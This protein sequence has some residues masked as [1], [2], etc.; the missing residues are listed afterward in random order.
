VTAAAGGAR[1]HDVIVVGAG[2]AGCVLAA[3]LSEDPSRQVLLLEAGPDYPTRER[4]PLDIADGARLPSDL[5][6]GHDWHFSS[7]PSRPGGRAVPLPRGRIVGGSSAVNGTFA[8]RGPAEDYDAWAAAGNDGWGSGDV[9]EVFCR[10]END[11]DFGDRPWHGDSG[12]VP[13]RRYAAEEQSVS[14]AAFLDAAEKAGHRPVADHNQPGALG[15]GPLPVNTLHRLRMSAALTHLEPARARPNLTVRGGATV[16]RVEFEAGRV[17]GV[18]LVGG[19][20]LSADLVVLAAG[21]YASPAILLRSGIGP[22]DELRAHGL[23]VVSDLPGVGRNLVDHPLAS[24]DVAV[25]PEPVQRP[26][27]QTMVTWSSDGTD[28]PPDLHLF[29]C[30]PFE[31]DRVGG[32]E[33]LLVLCVGLLDPAGRGQVQLSSSD[34]TVPPRID[35]GHLG[36]PADADRLIAGIAAARRILAAEPLASLARGAELSPGRDVHGDALREALPQLVRTY[37]HPVG[38]CRMGPATDPGAVVDA[39]GRLHGVD[40]LVVADASIMPTV[41]RANTN[42]PTLMLAER[43]AGWLTRPG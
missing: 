21:A 15:A 25:P 7:V 23:N 39:R 4:L 33:S 35:P 5:G 11:L 2:S 43:I 18:R 9:L 13:V 42:L 28:G 40:G 37:H 34:P 16:D 6:L 22:A 38:T 17:R 32:D 12:P 27:Y 19:E 10:L 36:A 30:G 41:P 29:A 8:L 20:R 3:R 31:S 26:R 24:V 1:R 14:A